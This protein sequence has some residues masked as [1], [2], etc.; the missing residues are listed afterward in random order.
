MKCKKI[1][2]NERW[3]FDEAMEN[4]DWDQET[5]DYMVAETI[6]NMDAATLN[7]FWRQHN[8]WKRKCTD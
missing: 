2:F 1:E 6:K 3:Q 4:A 5:F 7:E 8:E